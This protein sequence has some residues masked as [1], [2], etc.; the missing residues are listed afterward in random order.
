MLGNFLAFFL[1]FSPV[2]IRVVGI[3]NV[4]ENARKIQNA[5]ETS[6]MRPLVS[7]AI[8]SLFYVIKVTVFVVHLKNLKISKKKG[9]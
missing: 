3:N 8:F 2:F 7:K 1:Q 6:V 9:G 5:S 4:S